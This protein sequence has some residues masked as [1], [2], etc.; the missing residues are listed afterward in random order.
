M[1]LNKHQAQSN[2]YVLYITKVR[3]DMILSSLQ[4]VQRNDQSKSVYHTGSYNWGFCPGDLYL[5]QIM[6]TELMTDTQRL[7]LQTPHL[8]I[9]C[10]ELTTWPHTRVLPTMAAGKPLAWGMQFIAYDMALERK[11]I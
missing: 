2:L 4:Y 10:R 9:S 11:N 5:S 1:L 7:F 6:A 8:H 3:Y